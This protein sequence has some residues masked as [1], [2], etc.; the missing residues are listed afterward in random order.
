MKK[1]I[2]AL[3]LV[4]FLILAGLFY[5]LALQLAKYKSADLQHLTIEKARSAVNVSLSSIDRAL[6]NSDDIALLTYIESIAKLENVTSAFILDNNNTVI[7]HNNTNEWNSIRKDEIYD[8]AI[9]YN[10]E[11]L[12]LSHDRDH[13]LFSAPL[14]GSNT[15]CCIFS[16]Q[17]ASENA[18]YWKIKYMTAAAAAAIGLIIILY[19]LSKLFILLPFNRTKKRLEL[20]SVENIKDGKYD[21][22]TDLFAT[23]SEKLTRKIKA[24]QEDKSSL[25]KIIGYYSG[26]SAKNYSLFVILD[27]SN[28]IVYFY[29]T[30]EKFLK[31]DIREGINILEASELTEIL[32]I[33]SD[34]NDNPGKELSC[35]INGISVTT[36]SIPENGKVSATIIKGV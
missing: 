11:L 35:D 2:I 29:D 20:S 23:E 30:T 34:A 31:K 12:Q 21:E 17:K 36:V 5:L 22:I 7:I 9:N 1:N 4:F 28:N 19:L 18:G 27:S 13:I 25:T 32:K 16:T 6:K 3:N 26:M 8:M 33:I 10:G 15:L 24:L 14:Y